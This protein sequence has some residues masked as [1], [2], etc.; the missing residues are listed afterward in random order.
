MEQYKPSPSPAAASSTTQTSN[1]TPV[2]SEM[3]G[4]EDIALPV[5]KQSWL[6]TLLR[7][8]NLSIDLFVVILVWTLMKILYY[9]WRFLGW[10]SKLTKFNVVIDYIQEYKHV[11][12]PL[13]MAL[14]SLLGVYAMLFSL[15]LYP[16]YFL[17]IAGC[18]GLFF[19]VKWWRGPHIKYRRSVYQR[20]RYRL[21][22]MIPRSVLRFQRKWSVRLSMWYRINKSALINRVKSMLTGGKSD[23]PTPV[24]TSGSVQGQGEIERILGHK[25]NPLAE[26]Y[27]PDD[28]PDYFAILKITEEETADSIK[29]IYRKMSLHVHPDKHGGAPAAIAAFQLVNDAY[30]TLT[31]EEKRS[32]YLFEMAALREKRA[33]R[34][35]L[36]NWEVAVANAEASEAMEEELN[37]FSC[38]SCG[39]EHRRNVTD[40]DA[41]HCRW[42]GDCR[43]YHPA[44]LGEGWGESSGLSILSSVR[45]YCNMDNC[46]YE[47][48]DYMSCNA[49][50]VKTNTHT[51]SFHT[52]RLFNRNGAAALRRHRAER[53][54]N[55]AKK[56]SEKEK[57][58]SSQSN[59]VKPPVRASMRKS[60]SKR[61]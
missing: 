2:P 20:Y 27:D 5:S 23:K 6:E 60:F 49:M 59:V 1:T 22:S 40:R 53:E 8:M 9:P 7:W 39:G 13:F 57:E 58:K 29:K 26:D 3:D 38:A 46:I 34:A 25:P 36:E 12:Y 55:E 51:P 21:L 47:V 17:L 10:L 15:L 61:K 33:Q 16:R 35:Q 42:C 56:R 28:L 30:T 4:S 54:R 24:Q 32:N 44:L 19:F 37:T 43:D 45:Y 18:I 11:F 50:D 31:V 52:S 14:G 41:S 48:T